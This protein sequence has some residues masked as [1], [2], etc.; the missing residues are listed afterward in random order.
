MLSFTLILFNDTAWPVNADDNSANCKYGEGRLT[1][2]LTQG[3][4]VKEVT[5]LFIPPSPF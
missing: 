3:G 2:L 1:L 4:V 5:E